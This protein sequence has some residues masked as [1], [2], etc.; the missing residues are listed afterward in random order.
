MPQT[1]RMNCLLSVDKYVNRGL[2]ILQY[3]KIAHR[4]FGQHPKINF[5]LNAVALNFSAIYSVMVSCSMLTILYQ[6]VKCLKNNYW[7]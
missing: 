4:L 1:P 3:R 5:C 7:D 6:V 2:F